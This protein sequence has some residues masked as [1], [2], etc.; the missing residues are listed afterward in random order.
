[1]NPQQLFNIVNEPEYDIFVLLLEA[2]NKTRLTRSL[3]REACPDCLEICRR[4]IADEQDFK[5]YEPD[6]LKLQRCVTF[7]TDGTPPD[8]QTLLKFF[9][10][11]QEWTKDIKI[12]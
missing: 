3:Y 7:N 8:Q 1:M 9:V 12:V 10:E 4:F 2:S 11:I 6:F 5:E